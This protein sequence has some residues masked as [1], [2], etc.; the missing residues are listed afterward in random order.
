MKKRIFTLCT[1]NELARGFTVMQEL[2][3]HLSLT[4]Y[5]DIY[6]HAHASDG[7]EII[8]VEIQDHNDVQIVALMGYRIL[9]DFVRGKHLYVDDLITT[10]SVRSRGLGAELLSIAE[11]EAKRHGCASLRLCT[12]I[13]NEGGVR[14]YERNGWRKRSFAYVK[15]C[16]C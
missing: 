11:Q 13:E 1:D 12:G 14:F 16:P 8:A 4:D 15:R 2:R 6:R 5:L 3:P 7:Y 10:E 9:W